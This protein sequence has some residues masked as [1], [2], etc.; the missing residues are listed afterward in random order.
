LLNIKL[1]ESALAT[2]Y[3]I[4]GIKSKTK[5]VQEADLLEIIQD[6]RMNKFYSFNSILEEVIF[7]N[8]IYGNV[9]PGKWISGDNIDQYA[10][11][12]MQNDNDMLNGKKIDRSSYFF[13][14]YYVTAFY[15]WPTGKKKN[16]LIL[17][18]L[19]QDHITMTF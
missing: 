13:S 17:L 5:E 1:N 6:C 9:L 4:F 10:V 2:V 3:K 16:I 11:L 12:L 14:S 15:L 18:N 7:L 8:S 19:F